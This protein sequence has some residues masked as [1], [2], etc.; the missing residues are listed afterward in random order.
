MTEAIEV[1]HKDALVD[2]TLNTPENGNLVSN[3]MGARIIAAL[4]SLPAETKLVRVLGA[5]PDFCRGRVSPMPP[6]GARVTAAQIKAVVADPPLR[7]Y[8][9][10][11]QAPVPVLCAVKGHALGVGC[12]IVAA[13]DLTIAQAD[14]VFQVP[15]MEHDIPPL[16]VMTALIHKIPLKAVGHLVLSCERIGAAQAREWG[17]VSQIAAT[18]EFDHAV[19]ALTRRLLGYSLASLRAIKDYLRAAKEM[20]QD[21]ATAFAG[22]L[23]GTA[24]SARFAD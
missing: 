5:G 15:E 22:N 19:D 20:T 11:R 12:A 16:L 14:A 8:N 17:I 1:E 13:C 23:S 24:L 3:E 18:A 2:V 9:I 10:F 7:L 21:G 6:K 4:S